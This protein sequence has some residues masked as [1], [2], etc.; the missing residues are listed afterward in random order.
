MTRDDFHER[1][2]TPGRIVKC[3]QQECYTHFQD[4]FQEL[5]CREGETLKV[6]SDAFKKAREAR[7]RAALHRKIYK[8]HNP[9]YIFTCSFKT[10]SGALVAYPVVAHSGQEAEGLL[11]DYLVVLE[12]PFLLGTIEAMNTHIHPAPGTSLGV[13][14]NSPWGFEEDREFLLRVFT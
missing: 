4:T 5:T 13:Q 10:P 1:T 9:G 2:V 11:H 8:A 3:S 6:H 7:G 14:G 12:L